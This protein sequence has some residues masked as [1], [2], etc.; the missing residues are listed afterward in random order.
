M[1]VMYDKDGQAVEVPDAE[2]ANRYLAGELGFD[3]SRPVGLLDELGRPVDVQVDNLEG[4]FRSGFTYDTA[5]QRAQRAREAE[6]STPGQQAITFGEGLGGGV[7]FGLSRH[8]QE[9]LGADPERMRARAEVNPGLKIAGEVT[10]A[11]LP[12]VL[13]GGTGVAGSVARSLPS[14]AVAVGARGIEGFVARKL[15]VEALEAVAGGAVQQI[16]KRGVLDAIVR[17][18][19]ATAGSAVEGALYGVGDVVNE[20]ALGETEITAE[21]LIAGAKMGALLSGGTAGLFSLGGQVAKNAVRRASR[22]LPENLPGFSDTARDQALRH[23]DAK[24]AAGKTQDALVKRG[25]EKAFGDFLLKKGIVEA[26]DTIEASTA[27]A[28]QLKEAAGKAI[29]EA[30]NRFDEFAPP[31]AGSLVD[32]VNASGIATPRITR[33]EILNSIRERVL[34]P[35]GDDPFTGAKALSK[36]LEADLD[37]LATWGDEV[38]SFKGAHD[39]KRLFDKKIDYVRAALQTTDDLNYNG[40]LRDMRRVVMDTID[41]KAQA[42]S[43]AATGTDELYQ[44]Y[45]Q[46]NRDF[47]FAVT[48]EELGEHTIARRLKNRNFG[49]TDNI[50]GNAAA[51]GGALLTGSGIAGLATGAVFAG[52]NKL[53]RERGNA[54]IAGTLAKLAGLEGSSLAVTKAVKSNVESLFK[55]GTARA[56]RAIAPASVGALGRASYGIPMGDKEDK[57]SRDSRQAAFKRYSNELASLASNPTLLTDRLAKGVD[58]IR[59]AA[60]DVSAAMQMKATTA[61]QFLHSKMP[62]NPAAAK[63]MNP[64]IREWRPSDV[65][66][67]KF[68]R[69]VE[70]VENPMSV[71][72]DLAQ[73]QLSREGVESLQVCYPK[74]YEDVVAQVTENVAT[75]EKQLPYSQRLQLS[76]LLDVPVEASTEPAFVADMQQ[77][78]AGVQAAAQQQEAQQQASMRKAGFD[79]MGLGSRHATD[80]ERLSGR[81]V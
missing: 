79:K 28:T 5:E 64:A 50:A 32:E 3:G 60:P 80:T 68:E 70:A 52:I 81:S 62:K 69:Y 22:L 34:K 9:A 46:A 36:R 66:M 73:G 20:S 8:V 27:K 7:T 63:T 19:P 12:A 11:V 30:V 37:G 33:T 71:L 16:G 56:R 75:L 54:V 2:V 14:G 44:A 72:E 1:A 49:L 47:R 45:K 43:K 26:G 25:E 61:V 42:L 18:I 23:F 51:V 41:D 40:A 67:S 77:R 38:M 21:R 78:L 29:G 10:G 58:G 59:D 31:S 57:P 65:Q 24:G 76:I 4:A 48:A 39:L 53:A 55:E 35:L 74:M 13:S 17:A 6:F 15:G